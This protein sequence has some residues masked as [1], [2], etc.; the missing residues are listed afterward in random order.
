MLTSPP[1]SNSQPHILLV[2]DDSM[3]KTF[4]G[5]LRQN[6]TGL[7]FVLDVVFQ[8]AVSDL[9]T[10]GSLL[11]E[12]SKSE[13]LH[14]QIAA[15]IIYKN[16]LQDGDIAEIEQLQTKLSQVSTQQHPAPVYLFTNDPIDSDYRSGIRS[17]GISIAEPIGWLGEAANASSFLERVRRV[18]SRFEEPPP[19][20]NGPGNSP[21]PAPIPAGVG[22]GPPIKAA[23][24]QQ[25]V[26]R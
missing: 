8:T 16:E 20:E 11:A 18:I 25:P 24:N 14:G 12:A 13:N 19:G 7:G 23:G 6:L 1:P 10:K 26:P 15:V 3:R 2:C 21:P 17:V 5:F 4:E 22:G 9:E